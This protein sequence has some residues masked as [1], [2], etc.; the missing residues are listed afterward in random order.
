MILISFSSPPTHTPPSLI[1]N[2]NNN[3][4]ST[5]IYDRMTYYQRAPSPRGDEDPY[6]NTDR[7]YRAPVEVRDRDRGRDY[8]RSRRSP[9][10]PSRDRSP[11]RDAPKGPRSFHPAPAYRSRSGSQDRTG[12]GGGG[13]EGN[14]Y[15]RD[16][17]RSRSPSRDGDREWLGGPASRDVII[18]GLGLEVD[19]DYVVN[20]PPWNDYH[21]RKHPVALP[22]FFAFPLLALCF[23][24][25]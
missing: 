21:H 1:D 18:E 10:S 11:P 7:A 16:A 8:H 9:Y 12:G 25:S 17:P 15:D 14:Y 13:R 23:Y 5:S 3:N 6:Y 24:T 4:N 19:E 2:N 22:G 20:P